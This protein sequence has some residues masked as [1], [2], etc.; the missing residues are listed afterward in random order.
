MVRQRKLLPAR[1]QRNQP[2]DVDS[3]LLRSAESIGRLI[4]ALQ[5]QLDGARNQMGSLR[6][7][8][9]DGA[10]SPTRQNGR[11][12]QKP[13]ASTV[14]SSAQAGRAGN[15]SRRKTKTT[16]AKAA[17][18]PRSIRAAATSKRKSVPPTTTRAR[19][20]RKSR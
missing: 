18:T 8:D 2:Q 6:P 9:T 5:R 11:R 19:S 13:A 12:T 3:I 7:G 16:A 4:G 17:S 1:K 15:G 10:S 14:K 20:A